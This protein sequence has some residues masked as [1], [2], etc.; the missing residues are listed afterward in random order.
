M[1]DESHHL[2]PKEVGLIRMMPLVLWSK[3]TELIKQAAEFINEEFGEYINIISVDE[4][5]T[6]ID[7]DFDEID[8]KIEEYDYH[9]IKFSDH[10]AELVLKDSTRHARDFEDLEEL[11]EDFSRRMISFYHKTH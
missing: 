7:L 5:L 9:L 4:I 8:K 11:L 6:F 10:K 3:D 2:N 1:H